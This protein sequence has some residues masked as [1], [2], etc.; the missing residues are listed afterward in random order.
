MGKDE[1]QIRQLVATWLS[2]T[3]AGDTQT[4]MSLMTEDAVFLLPGQVMNKADFERASQQF[5][6]VGDPL[7]T[8]LS[9]II[10][11]N[12]LGEWAF[13]RSYLEVS[14]TPPKA[15]NPIKRAGHTL[16]IFQKLNGNWL[17]ARDANLMVAVE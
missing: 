3:Q 4:V 5:K 11:I 8:F 9:D 15:A 6:S 12:V 16:T 14:I 1:L 13:M 17:L 2:A 10:E 7:V